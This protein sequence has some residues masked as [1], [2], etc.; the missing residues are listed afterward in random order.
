V[1][2]QTLESILA[3]EPASAES[4][5]PVD[6][7]E[8]LITDPVENRIGTDQVEGESPDNPT[9]AQPDKVGA[10]FKGVR[11]GERKRYTEAI[12]DFEKKLEAQ[13]AAWQ[14]RFDQLTAALT[15]RQAPAARPTF[16]KTRKGP[17]V[18]SLCPWCRRRP[19]SVSSSR[20]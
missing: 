5:V 2:D 3:S 7:Q 14:T 10:A 19:N 6:E 1:T 4:P 8:T 11:E 13:N 12:T 17:S 15:P 18:P 9:T 20:S 16:L